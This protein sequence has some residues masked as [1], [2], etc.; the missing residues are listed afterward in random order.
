MPQ[1]LAS[2]HRETCR[3]FGTNVALRF[4]RWG[5]YQDLSWTGYRRQADGAAAGLI[6]LGINPGDRIA[7]LSE[8]RCE[9]LI[10]DHAI[11]SCGAADVP[12]HAPLTA[13]QA[14][15]QLEHS[16]ARGLFVSSQEQA[17]KIAAILDSL[18]QLEFMISF[19]PVAPPLRL[20]H[21]AWAGLMH[22]G[23][24][25][26]GAAA[27]DEILRREA[28]LSG[29]DLATLIYTSGTTGNPKGVMLTHDNLLSN[30]LATRQLADVQPGDVQLSWQCCRSVIFTRAPSTTT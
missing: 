13:P 29:N 21:L 1:N 25:R 28:A 2:F 3:R 27:Q 16:D 18:P 8:N 26:G 17:D 30:A 11:L 14:A 10:A 12:L 5:R 9:W 6:E 22:R 24:L 20:K 19:E 23:W 7:I 15:Y 4:K